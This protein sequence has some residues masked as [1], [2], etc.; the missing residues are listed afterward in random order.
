MVQIDVTFAQSQQRIGVKLNETKQELDVGFAHYQKGGQSA[1]ADWAQNDPAGA[2]YIKGRTHW[3]DDD[4]TVHKLSENFL[5]EVDGADA[6]EALASADIVAPAYQ[7]G[8]FYTAGGGE[9]Y[10]I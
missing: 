8:A 5:P 6:L 4:G 7:D 2:G 1:G 3:V 10:T 9:I